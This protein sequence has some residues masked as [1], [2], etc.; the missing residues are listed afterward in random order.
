MNKKA[1]YELLVEKAAAFEGWSLQKMQDA[2][3]GPGTWQ[4]KQQV[5]KQRE[6]IKRQIALQQA[7]A[8][9]PSLAEASKLPGAKAQAPQPTK[10]Q[11]PATATKPTGTVVGD[12]ARAALPAPQMAKSTGSG[13]GNFFSSLFTSDSRQAKN[14]KVP[15]TKSPA[16]QNTNAGLKTRML[17][18]IDKGTTP[19][20][21]AD[22]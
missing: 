4:Y 11:A 10:T 12:V 15:A 7:A 22:I 21:I 13:I 3:Y 17:N 16:S 8:S 2:G 14:P 6:M 9:Q 18:K 20:G 5:Q 19:A 1:A